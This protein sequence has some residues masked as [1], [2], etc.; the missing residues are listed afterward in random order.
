MSSLNLADQ[1][2]SWSAEKAKQLLSGWRKELGFIM[3]SSLVL[4]ASSLSTDFT[5][6]HI[7]QSKCQWKLPEWI[8][9]MLVN[10][11]RH[12]NRESSLSFLWASSCWSCLFHNQYKPGLQFNWQQVDCIRRI[13][14]WITG[15]LATGKISSF[16]PWFNFNL[17]AVAC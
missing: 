13:L 2:F 14:S 16:S 5:G 1:F 15:C 17:R 12:F 7:P 10:F 4:S 8:C 9:N 3:P 6:N 11:Q